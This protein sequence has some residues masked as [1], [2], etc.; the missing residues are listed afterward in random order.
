MKQLPPYIEG[1]AI[2]K[3]FWGKQW[4]EHLESFADYDNRLQRGRTYVRNGSVCHLSAAEGE[5]E[6][7]VSGTSL[8]EVVVKIK[9]LPKDKWE[10]IKKRCSE[11]IGS[12]IDFLQGKVPDHVMEVVSDHKEG[13]FPNLNEITYDCSCPD[14][15]G[16]CKH[17]AAVLYGIGN[18]MDSQ[19]ELLF[20]LRGVDPSELINTNL[21]LDVETEEGQLEEHELADIFG[22]DFE[23]VGTAVETPAKEEKVAKSVK[24]KNVVKSI[25]AGKSAKTKSS[26][27]E[28]VKTAKIAQVKKSVKKSLS[29]V[30]DVDCLTGTQIAELR[31]YHGLSV[32]DFADKLVVSPATVMR[33]EMNS[34]ALKLQS[35]SKEALS[36][37]IDMMS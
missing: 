23:E 29:F 36:D 6:A 8:Y 28:E 24:V 35:N 22:L 4:C 21:K 1:R 5:V 11:H 14:W 20:S 15:A 3:K 2:A 25:K 34:N 30:W 31:N 13:L 18:R 12:L 33:W 7:I 10:A 37:F 27:I 26:K 32:A 16:M 19:P 9:R 17:V